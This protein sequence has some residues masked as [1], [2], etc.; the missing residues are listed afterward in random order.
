MFYFFETTQLS[1]MLTSD[2]KYLI[3]LR[4]NQNSENQISSVYQ[5]FLKNYRHLA[6]LFER[7]L[8]VAYK[9]LFTGAL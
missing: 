7:I 6:A 9:R 3:H 2:E 4:E 5:N 8:N 1:K